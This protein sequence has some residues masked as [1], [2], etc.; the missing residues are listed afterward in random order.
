MGIHDGLW[1]IF[2]DMMVQSLQRPHA[3]HRLLKSVL[4]VAP[5]MS[6]AMVVLASVVL[7]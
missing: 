7:R 6:A 1:V 5:G 3:P 4:L 2:E